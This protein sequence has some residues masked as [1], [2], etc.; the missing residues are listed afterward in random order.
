M[1]HQGKEA[2]TSAVHHLTK[3][4]HLQEVLHTIKETHVQIVNQD[5]EE[6]ARAVDKIVKI[7][8]DEEDSDSNEGTAR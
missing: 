1:N 3:G 6:N 4:K 2:R 7:M 5:P 8:T